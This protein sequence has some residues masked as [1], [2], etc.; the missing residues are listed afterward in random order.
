MATITHKTLVDGVGLTTAMVALYTAPVN[1]TTKITRA[2]FTNNYTLPVTVTINLVPSGVAINYTNQI[3]KEY[4]LAAGKTWSCPDIENHNIVAGT[5]IY[6]MASVTGVV[7][8]RISGFEI[9]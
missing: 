2:T 1:T 4:V 8:C 6:M 7:G 5:I 9:A 3:A